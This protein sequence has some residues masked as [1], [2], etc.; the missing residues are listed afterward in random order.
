MTEDFEWHTLPDMEQI[1][2]QFCLVQISDCEFAVIGGETNYTSTDTS[3]W[4]SAINIYNFETNQWTAG[5]KYAM[6][7]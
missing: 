5:P 4:T 1:L 3:T 6:I 7:N 2:T